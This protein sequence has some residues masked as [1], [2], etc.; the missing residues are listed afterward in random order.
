[1]SGPRRR[2]LAWA[3]C[4]AALLTAAPVRAA[5]EVLVATIDGSINPASADYLM[6]A[7]ERAG[8]EDAAA[9]L[10]ELDTPGGLLSS[11]KDILGAILAS[12]VPVIV[13]VSPTGAW[14]AS[15]GVFIT[16]SG[17]VAAMAPG[18][19]IG[20]AHPVFGT[21]SG[22]PSPATPEPAED[23]EEGAEERPRPAMRDYSMEKAENLTAAY[24]ESIARK[25][26]RN[27]EWAERAVRAAIAVGEEEAVE[28]NVVDLVAPSRRALLE[29][30]EGRKIE[31]GDEQIE[32]AV[33]DA[34]VVPVEMSWSQAFFNY[35]ASPDMASILL[36]AGLLGL[37][38]EF[39][40]PGLIV[41][42]LLGATCMML[43]GIALQ[44]LP[45][46]WVGLLVI[47]F[48]V[49]LLVAE[50][51]VT[52]FGILFAAGIACLLFGGAM[53]FE[54]PD[55]S[56]LTVDFWGVLVPAVTAVAIFGGLVVFA[57]S[58]SLFVAQVA[59]VDELVGLVARA[60]SP[61]APVGRVFVRGEYWTAR[62][63]EDIEA[64]EPVEITAVEGLS[65]Q[66]RRAAGA[67]SSAARE[68]ST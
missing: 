58:R 37:Y 4:A 29:A 11:T 36:M 35:L 56:N 19:S 21:G 28:L 68:E 18:T 25:R 65:L 47:A 67:V 64:G 27:A 2:L 13:Y 1:V 53:L 9:L 50:I 59:G 7:I 15:A 43:V 46:S 30:I 32:L 39:N 38:I 10:L 5:G 33:A 61:I 42:G 45:F 48:G 40:N 44:I 22:G 17:H 41:P 24:I 60:A 6:K 3:V 31:V 57:L 66:V 34:P 63:E 51:F 62:S 20:A 54:R 14:A 23:G 12:D 16:L 26:G 8:D 49:A 52:S 55:V